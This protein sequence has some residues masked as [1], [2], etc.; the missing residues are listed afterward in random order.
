VRVQ[1]H[2]GQIH[3]RAIYVARVQ[4]VVVPADTSFDEELRHFLVPDMVDM[5]YNRYKEAAELLVQDRTVA[6]PGEQK[7]RL[8]P[9]V[10]T[11]VDHHNCS[12]G[13]QIVAFIELHLSNIFSRRYKRL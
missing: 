5:S 3:A 9:V 6:G 7:Y 2:T 4:A 13:L 12:L 1:L 8:V 11:S 10:H